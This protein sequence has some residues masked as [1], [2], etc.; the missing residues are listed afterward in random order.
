MI[1]P[2]KTEIKNSKYVVPCCVDCNTELG[3]IL[4]NPIKALLC[5]S[6]KEVCEELDKNQNLYKK[7]YHWAALI[8]F[9]TH[10]KDKYLLKDQDRRKQSGLISDDFCWHCLY[11]IHNV[12]RQHYTGTKISNGAYG[13]ILV[14]ES[15]RE[16]KNETFD[17]LDN[18]NSQIVMIQVGSIV[19][20]V[21][22]TDCQA[23]LGLYKTFFSRISGS[24]SSAQIRE[25][26]ARLRYVIEN[27]KFKPT[28]ITSFKDNNPKIISKIRDKFAMYEGSEERKSLFELMKSYIGDIIPSTIP[29]R[30]KLL[31]DLGEGKAQYIFDE[32]FN[33]FQHKPY[34][35]G[36]KKNGTQ[37]IRLRRAS[38]T[39]D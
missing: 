33:F 2:N 3:T 22:L 39:N 34:N 36:E 10:L 14:Y 35:L 31:K 11:H 38:N 4:E 16:Q 29:N 19:I 28:F 25:V 21:T 5:K 12:A 32:N 1:L 17:Y 27:L 6:Y 13:T 7:I 24:L 18:F 30:E 23:S 26:F 37:Q 9:K 8:F 20:F 15:L